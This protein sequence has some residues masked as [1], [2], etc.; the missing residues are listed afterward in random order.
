MEATNHPAMTR[1]VMECPVD[2]KPVECFLHKVVNNCKNDL[3]N[4]VKESRDGQAARWHIGVG[5]V[6]T[7]SGANISKQPFC[8][9]CWCFRS[10]V[11]TEREVEGRIVGRNTKAVRNPKLMFGLTAI[12]RKGFCRGTAD[13]HSRD[14]PERWTAA[15]NLVW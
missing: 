2:G 3:G 6:V 4:V 9:H 12:G 7:N 5:V 8:H 11:L 10:S 14:I 15:H 1:I 13:K